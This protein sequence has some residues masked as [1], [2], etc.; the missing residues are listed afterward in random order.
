MVLERRGRLRGGGEVAVVV[1]VM[2]EV[3]VEVESYLPTPCDS[4][5]WWACVT[6]CGQNQL[7]A[8]AGGAAAGGGVPA[9]VITGEDR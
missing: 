4:G 5:K 2:V 1:V 7:A 9:A 6:G 8:A 3:E